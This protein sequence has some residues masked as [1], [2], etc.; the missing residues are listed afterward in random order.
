MSDIESKF[1]KKKY[2]KKQ[3]NFLK[4]F[5][6]RVLISLIIFMVLLI[7]IKANPKLKNKINN[8][9]YENNISF[10]K[11]N[12]W[13][14]SKFGNI[15]P[16]DNTFPKEEQVFNEKL[17][18]SKKSTYKDGVKLTVDSNYLVPIIESGVVV[19]I[20]EKEGYGNVVIVQQINGIDTWYGNVDVNYKLYDYIEKGK[21]LGEA[22]DQN[23]Y[24]V[25]QKEGKTLDYKKYIS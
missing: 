8:V 4:N 13:Y 16:L 6:S 21:L 23:I 3:N 12:D 17:S 2:E 19:F 14:K 15:I 11:F 20:G 9:L 22:R 25:F 10:A 7:T 5:V 1:Y 24:L 18:Y